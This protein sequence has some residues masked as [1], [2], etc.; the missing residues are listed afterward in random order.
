MTLINPNISHLIEN[1]LVEC[2]IQPSVKKNIKILQLVD[3]FLFIIIY[4]LK[5]QQ[6]KKK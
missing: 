5:K 4:L 6:Q 2:G 3:F 1:N